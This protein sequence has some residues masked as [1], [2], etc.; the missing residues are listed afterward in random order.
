[1]VTARLH[2]CGNRIVPRELR[3]SRAQAGNGVWQVLDATAANI[4]R[5][6]TLFLEVGPLQMPS[7]CV[8]T[9]GLPDL[10]K[11]LDKRW[12]YKMEGPVNCCA[13]KVELPFLFC[14]TRTN[15]RS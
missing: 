1:M 6:G 10:T 2:G 7:A 8:K 15:G 9:A 3:Q 5:P 12:H 11:I 14:S 4:A 13:S